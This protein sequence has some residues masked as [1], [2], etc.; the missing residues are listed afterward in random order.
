[1]VVV[2]ATAAAS[3][4]AVTAAGDIMVAR[5]DGSAPRVLVAHAA[6]PHIG[7]AF[8]AISPNGRLVAAMT[9]QVRSAI[10]PIA[11]GKPVV[12][13][14]QLGACRWAPNSALLVCQNGFP[15]NLTVVNAATGAVRRI[16]SGRFNDGVS[17]SPDSRQVAVVTFT[18]SGRGERLEVITLATRK[19]RVLRTGTFFSGLGA[20]PDCIRDRPPPRPAAGIGH[21]HR[22]AEP[23]RP[24]PTDQVQA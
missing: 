6:Q 7:D 11:G 9:T 8:A 16:A 12:T 17:F 23:H 5:D 18:R 20:E 14:Q 15:F 13:S 22:E 21:L 2:P 1:M 19:A 4:A 10:Y 3:L 24:A